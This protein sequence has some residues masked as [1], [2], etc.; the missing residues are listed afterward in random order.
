MAVCFN[1]GILRGTQVRYI[2]LRSDSAFHLPNKQLPLSDDAIACVLTDLRRRAA[3]AQH[4]A[5]PMCWAPPREYFDALVP[6]AGQADLAAVAA[7]LEHQLR[8]T[9]A[10]FYHK[11]SCCVD[12]LRDTVVVRVWL[13][14]G[15]SV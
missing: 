2:P 13:A 7:Q 9:H 15:V 6:G 5:Q 3:V 11:A 1:A 12:A 4:Y 10:F 8:R 14:R